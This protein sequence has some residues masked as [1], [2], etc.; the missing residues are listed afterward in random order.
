MNVDNPDNIEVLM[1]TTD[2]GEKWIAIE[3]ALFLD[4]AVD[5]LIDKLESDKAICGLVFNSCAMHQSTMTRLIQYL[6]HTNINKLVVSNMCLT[7]QV[8]LALSHLL[9]ENKLEGLSLSKSQ[10]GKRGHQYIIRALSESS[11]KRLQLSKCKIEKEE[12]RLLAQTLP[13]SR[14]ETLRLDSAKLDTDNI[15]AICNAVICSPH[16]KELLLDDNVL[17]DTSYRAIREMIVRSQVKV[18]SLSRCNVTNARVLKLVKGIKKSWTIEAL[19]LTGNPDLT[20]EFVDKFMRKIRHHRT[21]ELLNIDAPG[22]SD[23]WYKLN[24]QLS[25][26]HTPKSTLMQIMIYSQYERFG[27]NSKLRMLPMDMIRKLMTFI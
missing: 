22:F 20:P 19:Y 1:H 10:I 26:L 18:V 27:A 5:Q 24:R 16:L 3:S 15:V 7:K 17:D 14:L 12:V 25:R 23:D 2:D 21:L 4:G 9:K 6:K 13:Y 11:L 8:A